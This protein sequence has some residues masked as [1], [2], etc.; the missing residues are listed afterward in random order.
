MS[1]ADE[2]R[3][4]NPGGMLPD[5]VW[6]KVSGAPGVDDFGAT[7]RGELVVSE[8]ILEVLVADGLIV[9]RYSPWM[10][11]PA[12]REARL[13]DILIRHA[14][15]EHEP[16]DRFDSL[17]V[18]MDDGTSSGFSVLFMRS[19]DFD[20]DSDLDLDPYCISTSSGASHYGGITRVAIGRGRVEIEVSESAAQALGAE[21]IRWNF[22]LEVS[23][24]E[25]EALRD[26]LRRVFE[27]KT[28]LQAL[29]R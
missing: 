24:A 11:Q 8:K 10:S 20:L 18:G 15:V 1:E 22:P 14:G 13:L 29:D 17:S 26:G 25:F 7:A 2:F 12:E 3:D 23:D 28:R 19:S 21:S 5:L 6:I 4:I 9:G 16:V 27:P